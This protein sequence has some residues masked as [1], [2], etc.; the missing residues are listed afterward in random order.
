MPGQDPDTA[1]VWIAAIA[2]L[3]GLAACFGF[4][5][6]LRH[7]A[8]FLVLDA[9]G[10]RSP[11]FAGH[12]KWTSVSGITVAGGR[13][14]TTVL[15][16]DPA[17]ALPARTGRIWRVWIRRRRP[18]VVFSGLTPRGMKARAYLDLLARYQRAALARAELARRGAP[19]AA[20]FGHEP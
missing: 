3:C 9:E 16:L 12:V 2:A 7:R 6:F 20:A 13:G 18:A 11:A 14:L 15:G 17:H 8:P 5:Q 10:F 4:L 1:I 19:D